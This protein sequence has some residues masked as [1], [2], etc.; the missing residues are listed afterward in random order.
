MLKIKDIVRLLECDVFTP[1][2]LNEEK[3]IEYAFSA[4]LMSDTLYVLNKVKNDDLLEKTL[5]ITGLATNQSVRSAEILDVEVVLI[6][7]GKTPSQSVIEQ[8]IEGNILLL[9]SKS[10]MFN[11]D[12]LLFKSGIRGITGND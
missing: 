6:V 11:A 8:A 3:E 9:G 10:T 12:G 5:L 7:R 2:L 1:S 4:D